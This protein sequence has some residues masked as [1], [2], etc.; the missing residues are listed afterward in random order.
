MITE[1]RAKQQAAIV[2]KRQAEI[3]A[4][5][6]WWRKQEKIRVEGFAIVQ[7]D[8]MYAKMNDHQATRDT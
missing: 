3:A 1:E 8:P 2:A 7:T 6:A 4:D 5:I